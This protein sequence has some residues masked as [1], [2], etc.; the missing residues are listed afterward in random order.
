MAC[1]AAA[2][3]LAASPAAAQ[4]QVEIELKSGEVRLATLIK[5]LPTTLQVEIGGAVL[6]L[7]KSRIAAVREVA[8]AAPATDDEASKPRSPLTLPWEA[9]GFEESLAQKKAR[10]AAEEATFP[11]VHRLEDTAR[12]R[13]A[14]EELQAVIAQ[15]PDSLRAASYLLDATA[16]SVTALKNRGEIVERLLWI[17]PS[18]VSD[19]EYGDLV[20]SLR[21][22]YREALTANSPGAAELG[23]KLARYLAFETQ[24]PYPPEL[25]AALGADPK[26]PSERVAILLGLGAELA[27]QAAQRQDQTLQ[28]RLRLR[29]EG[30][31]EQGASAMFADLHELPTRYY[32]RYLGPLRLLMQE[33]ILE[34][35]LEGN[36]AAVIQLVEAMHPLGLDRAMALDEFL[37]R[38]GRPAEER[39]REAWDIALQQLEKSMV[40]ENSDFYRDYAI[41]LR[42]LRS[43]RTR[44]PGEAADTAR[45]TGV[46]ANSIEQALHDGTSPRALLTKSEESIA[47]LASVLPDADVLGLYRLRDQLAVEAAA[48]EQ[49]LSILYLASRRTVEDTL[50]AEQQLAIFEAQTS[51]TITF[52][53]SKP[54]ALPAKLAENRQLLQGEI[55]DYQRQLGEY[56]KDIE[57]TAPVLARGI[58]YVESFLQRKMYSYD[59]SSYWR[60]GPAG[61]PIYRVLRYRIAAA[62]NDAPPHSIF[63]NDLLM[64]CIITIQASV[65]DMDTSGTLYREDVLFDVEYDW[66]SGQM[67]LLQ[68]RNP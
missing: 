48:Y 5:E 26:P 58:A 7:P 29:E 60:S 44:I 13:E 47:I 39:L 56:K 33:R 2:A 43:L 30:L 63:C 1:V 40:K 27:E 10:L 15:H 50:L 8:E 37:E 25:I 9:V 11:K 57:D 68:V 62:S 65:E 34:A 45:I 36:D 17:D 16:D 21:V 55:K 35:A 19:T 38:R 51:Q 20:E 3:V 28:Y 49:M 4:K 52:E 6:E 42:L 54:L 46:V 24:Q 41:N 22:R 23:E 66:R 12:L 31:R 14:A 18:L 32:D 53:K 59:T 67:K 64:V 61:V